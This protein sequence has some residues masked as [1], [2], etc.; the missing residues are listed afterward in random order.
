MRPHNTRPTD[1][2]ILDP[3][4]RTAFTLIELLVVIAII[5]IL[6]AMLM[7][8]LE[9]A[10]EKA[11]FTR[12]LGSSH[13]HQIDPGVAAYYNFQDIDEITMLS[14]SAVGDPQDHYY[15][16]RKL[17]ARISGATWIENGGRLEGKHAIHFNGSDHA[18]VERNNMLD[19]ERDE[20]F[21]IVAWIRLETMGGYAS[22][23]SKMNP[24]NSYRGYGMGLHHR[25]VRMHLIHKWS[26]DAIARDSNEKV[27]EDRWTMM[28]MTY[29]GGGGYNDIDLYIDAQ[30]VSGASAATGLNNTIQGDAVFCIAGR[31]R[32]RHFFQGLIDEVI[33]YKRKLSVAEIRGV[34]QSGRR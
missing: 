5:A 16:Q 21:S 8:A 20:P 23:V 34:Y 27:I 31:N 1:R 32:S 2:K 24:D 33:V 11:R 22:V 18:Y 4:A 12:W 26:G 3:N 6:A 14:N 30:R 29:D 7:P 19:F 17:D 28:C 13:N 25:T 9:M 10:R 15:D